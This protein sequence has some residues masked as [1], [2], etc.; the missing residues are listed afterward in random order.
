MWQASVHPHHGPRYRKSSASFCYRY[1]YSL[2]TRA[3]G[4]R[5]AE[6]PMR[7]VPMMDESIRHSRTH[8][9]PRTTV[10][11]RVVISRQR[12]Y[13]SHHPR[14]SN[15]STLM[16]MRNFERIQYEQAHPCCPF[17]RVIE[18]S[19]KELE[20]H[21]GFAFYRAMVSRSHT[22]DDDQ[23]A[24][25][26]EDFASADV[27]AHADEESSGDA[28]DESDGGEDGDC[29]SEDE[30][31]DED[32]Y[33]HGFCGTCMAGLEP[34]DW[35]RLASG[36]LVIKD[37][38]CNDCHDGDCAF[39]GSRRSKGGGA[40]HTCQRCSAC[41][42][43]FPDVEEM[44]V[45]DGL[46][47]DCG[48]TCESCSRR[49]DN[50]EDPVCDDCGMCM[51]CSMDGSGEECPGC[52]IACSGCNAILN[53]RAVLERDNKCPRC[54]KTV[55]LDD[56]GDDNEPSESDNKRRKLGDA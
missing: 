38:V 26:G 30:E 27:P 24:A 42:R 1:E 6:R 31:E 54:S 15:A 29:G 50:E 17:I 39:C 11:V 37:C 33:E 51:E 46:C 44:P 13:C 18:A 23:D 7:V 55:G 45:R 36:D 16:S 12:L 2:G 34:E 9:T 5:P 32:E 4:S 21:C 47:G 49:L 35:P 20:K 53:R 52:T 43:E 19:A 14:A 8:G 25:A 40:C 41:E 10:R 56:E 28:E 3:A 48:T 22:P